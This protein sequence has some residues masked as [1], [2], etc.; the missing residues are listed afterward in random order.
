MSNP[1]V[2]NGIPG[3]MTGSGKDTARLKVDIGQ[4]GFFERREFRISQQYSI[5]HGASLVFKFSSPVNFILWEQVITCDAN[6]VIFEAVV[7]GTP[8][9]TFDTPVTVW[10]KNRMDEQPL[11]V[12]QITISTGGTVSGGQVA[13]V[14]RVKS[15]NATAQQAS[16][17]FTASSERGLPA[18][19]YYLRLTADGGTATGVFSLIWEERP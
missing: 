18:G 4:T 2:P 14:V 5:A 6:I 8:I 9:G 1:Y 11:Y 19:D 3:V 13:E 10:G 16:V 12:G 15:A 17:G 7:G